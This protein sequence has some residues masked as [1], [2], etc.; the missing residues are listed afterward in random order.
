MNSN[1]I[2]RRRYPLGLVEWKDDAGATTMT[3]TMT[4]MPMTGVFFLRT[5]VASW[6]TLQ[7]IVNQT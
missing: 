6:L 3:M 4:T 5:Y 2:V 7:A 1:F